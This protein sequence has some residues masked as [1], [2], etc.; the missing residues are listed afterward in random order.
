MA[1]GRQF[2]VLLLDIQMREMNGDVL[3]ARLRAAGDYRPMIAVTGTALPAHC[4]LSGL[5]RS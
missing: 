5:Q 1:V 2:D 4:I 3:C